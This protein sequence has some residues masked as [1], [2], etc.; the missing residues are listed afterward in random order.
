MLAT[1]FF[2]FL[3]LNITDGILSTPDFVGLDNYTQLFKDPQVWST[4]STP[5]SLWVTI[6]FGLIALPM[7][8]FAPLG[9]AL[10]M[11][12]K[13]LK[14]QNF[15]RSLFYM[16]FIVPFVAAVFL[17]GGML[18]PEAAGSIASSYGW[19]SPRKMCRFGQMTSTGSIP[20]TSSWAFGALAMPC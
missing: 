14:G 2:S 11:N 7:G 4:G 16:P 1:F 10:L 12:N 9:L 3:N 13:H 20:P 19:G 18:N 17:W 5:G 8:I 15:F 6:R